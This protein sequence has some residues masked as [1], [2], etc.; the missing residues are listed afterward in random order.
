MSGNSS[1]LLYSIYSFLKLCDLNRIFVSM[2]QAPTF[3]FGIFYKLHSFPFY[4]CSIPR[5]LKSNNP[6]DWL[7]APGSASSMHVSFSKFNHC[8][9]PC[10]KHNWKIS[11]GTHLLAACNNASLT[12]SVNTSIYW[13]QASLWQRH[14]STVSYTHQHHFFPFKY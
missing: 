12:V 10:R 1:G 11:F 5:C 4:L 3:P 9:L 7:V 14:L 2:H 13:F 8:L 6:M